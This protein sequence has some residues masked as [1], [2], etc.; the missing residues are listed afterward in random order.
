MIVSIERDAHGHPNGANIML[1]NRQVHGTRQLATA[2][3]G[4]R[5]VT[6]LVDWDVHGNVLNVRIEGPFTIVDSDLRPESA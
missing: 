2:G 5:K 3:K 4:D 1:S 6:I